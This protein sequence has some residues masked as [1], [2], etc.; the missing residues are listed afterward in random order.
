MSDPGPLP[1]DQLGP[2]LRAERTRR[3]LSLRA[4]ADETKVSFNTLSRVERG[5]V[6]DLEAFQRIVGWMGYTPAQFLGPD[7]VGG[8]DTP[9]AVAHMLRSDPALS[10]GAATQIADLVR[11]LYASLSESPKEATVHLRAASTFTPRAGQLL[12]D[13]VDRMQSA[14]ESRD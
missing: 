9:D 10:E 5:H 13:L 6:P 11:N 7:K 14:L 4:L 1:L 2:L 8:V 3:G 12:A